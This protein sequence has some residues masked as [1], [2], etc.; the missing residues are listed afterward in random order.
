VTA[1]RRLTLRELYRMAEERAPVG[2]ALSHGLHCPTCAAA[3]GEPCVQAEI[4]DRVS[5]L[6]HGQRRAAVPQVEQIRAVLA[7]FE[8]MEQGEKLTALGEQM[9]PRD[10]DALVA[11]LRAMLAGGT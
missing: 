3:P 6:S 10:R 1:P 5:K 2:G 7:M 8:A 4:V 9:I 11:K